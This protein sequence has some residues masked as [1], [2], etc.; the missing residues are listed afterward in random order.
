M[1]QLINLKSYS[2]VEILDNYKTDNDLKN[3]RLNRVKYYKE[4]TKLII[5]YSLGNNINIVVI[6][7]GSVFRLFNL[8]TIEEY[9]DDD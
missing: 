9:Q 4:Q 1:D 2:N 5:D 6:G 8:T 3:R 7:L